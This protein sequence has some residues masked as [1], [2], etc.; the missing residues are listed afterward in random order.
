MGIMEKVS[1]I[2]NSYNDNQLFLSQ[3]IKSYLNQRKVDLQL[4]ISTVKKDPSIITAEKINKNI[5]V[6][7][8]EKAGIYS[9][10]N[11]ALN[12]IDGDWFA[13]ASGNDVAL[14]EKL[15]DEVSLCKGNKKVCYSA[16]YSSNENLKNKRL[17]KLRKYN[18]QQHLKGN[19]VSD[20]G[21]LR[22]DLLHKYMPFIEKYGNHA[23]WDFWLRIAEGEGP[24]CFVYN[25]KPEWIYRISKDS[26]HIRRKK[27]KAWQ[28]RN[29]KARHKMLADHIKSNRHIK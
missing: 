25:P 15:F 19:F 1:I 17:T 4:I 11:Y 5:D 13:Y 18:Y 12:Y 10:L 9:Q 23:Y 20:L 24:T 21:L 7:I 8:N 26:R 27:D 14:H 28:K 22:V 16:F 3:A 29:T 6:V 2:I